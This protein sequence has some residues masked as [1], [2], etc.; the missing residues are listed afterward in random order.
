MGLLVERCRRRISDI[1]QEVLLPD[2]GAP[3]SEVQKV[4]TLRSDPATGNKTIRCH[5]YTDDATFFN[6]WC[7]KIFLCIVF[8]NTDC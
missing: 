6:T 1:G 2:T 5:K 3:E 7:S 8:P 4:L